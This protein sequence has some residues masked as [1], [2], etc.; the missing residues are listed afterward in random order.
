MIIRI[1]NNYVV[2]TTNIFV[3]SKLFTYEQG[4]LVCH[5]AEATCVASTRI[6]SIL[7]AY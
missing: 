7:C 5:Y 3:I 6:Y 2:I 4:K 1:M